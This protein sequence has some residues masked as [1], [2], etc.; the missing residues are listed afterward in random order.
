MREKLFF[1]RG[2]PIDYIKLDEVTNVFYMAGAT[3]TSKLG[4]SIIH[5]RKMTAIK[6]TFPG[7][8][9]STYNMNPSVF[10]VI[11]RI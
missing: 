11:S 2:I 5:L 3:P 6:E 10:E 9:F 4:D 1:G 8:S 7:A